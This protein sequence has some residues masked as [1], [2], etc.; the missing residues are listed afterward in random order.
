MKKYITTI[1]FAKISVFVF[2]LFS[3]LVSAAEGDPTDLPDE[4]VD[5]TLP[6]DNYVWILALLGLIYVFLRFRALGKP[7]PSSEE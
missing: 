5:T 1:P 2:M 3:T 6:I 4:P 7:N